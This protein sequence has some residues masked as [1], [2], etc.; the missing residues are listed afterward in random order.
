MASLLGSRWNT[1]FPAGS[2][3]VR[4]YHRTQAALPRTNWENT[5]RVINA[6]SGKQTPRS[7]WWWS[8][9]AREE[10]SVSLRDPLP[11]LLPDFLEIL[12]EWRVILCT[13]HRGCYTR[14][15]ISRH[16]PEKLGLPTHSGFLCHF[17]TC[18]LRTISM[19]IM[20]QHCNQ[21]HR[22]YVSH[23]GRMPW[24]QAYFQPLFTMYQLVRHFMVTRQDNA[25]N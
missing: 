10:D 21:K 14:H 5:R 25:C 17:D 12:P 6:L 23:Q 16:L 2:S 19:D 15:N 7:S 20:R 3:G 9:K 8:Y 13:T 1:G 18:N 4:N 22:W 24:H 11:S